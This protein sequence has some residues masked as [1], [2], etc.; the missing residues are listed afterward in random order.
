MPRMDTVALARPAAGTRKLRVGV[1]QLAPGMYV[2]ELDR[3]WLD[4]PFL[5]EGFLIDSP[6]ELETL[7]RYCRYVYVDSERSD[8]RLTSRIRDAAAADLP[9]VKPARRPAPAPDPDT[10]STAAPAPADSR[11]PGVVPRARSDARV[12]SQ[13]RERF[14]RFVRATAVAGESLDAPTGVLGRTAGWLRRWMVAD[15]QDPLAWQQRSQQAVREL[16]PPGIRVVRPPDPQPFDE[17]L[18]GARKAVDGA[19]Q[20]AAELFEAVRDG[21]QVPVKAIADSVARLV[22]A[23]I[24]N[25]DAPAWCARL[26]EHPSR[27]VRH[28]V[29]VAVHLLAVG[30]SIGLDHESLGALATIGLLAD[31]GKARLPRSL[32]E[33]PGMLSASEH[34]IVK[35]HVRLGLE[36]IERGTPLATEVRIGIAQHHERLD[37][38][39]YPKGLH[40]SEISFW[41][42]LAAIA[43]SFAAL[44]SP[45]PYAAAL[46][47]QEAMMSLYEWAG[48]SFDEA[49]VEQF[50]QAIG[51]F[52]V[53]STVELSTGEIAMVIG[54]NHIRRLEPRVV[55]VSDAAR[56]PL[57][58]PVRRAMPSLHRGSPPEALRVARGLP[59]NAF[60]LGR[61]RLDAWSTKRNG[62]HA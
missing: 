39:G 44:V 15:E 10:S 49:L 23:M 58:T 33:K 2:V 60:D 11:R 6:I 42:R 22:A 12:S 24:A 43:D 9:L 13:T 28:A 20:A 47:P 48:S 21:R 57:A 40:G 1:D 45:R 52:P 36:A 5:L 54:H 19:S 14:R 37:G 29:T 25:P 16:L 8:A 56:R 26:H 35:E 27:D 34:T 30:R 51:I 46:A 32:L 38:S 50:V 18:P 4:T 31:A 53:G 41:G 17:A 3:P 7:R 55:V 61:I 59:A 62:R